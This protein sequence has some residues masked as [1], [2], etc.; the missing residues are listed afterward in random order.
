MTDQIMGLMDFVKAAKASITEVNGTQLDEMRRDRSDLMILDV[1]ESSEHE[2]GYL[3]G[4]MLVPR[5][6]LEAAADFN[7]PKRV[8]ALVDARDRPIVVYCASGGRSAMA[9]V[10]LKQMG[11]KEV[12]SLAGGVMQWSAENRPLLKEARYV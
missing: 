8:Q 12:Y 6:I 11:F 5:G 1:R 4:A 10:T 2:Q 3:E 9:A 7:Y